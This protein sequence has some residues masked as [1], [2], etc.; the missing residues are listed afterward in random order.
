[1]TK[2]SG[3]VQVIVLKIADY[4]LSVEQISNLASEF[5]GEMLDTGNTDVNVEVG[6][7]GISAKSNSEQFKKYVDTAFIRKQ[8]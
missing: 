7:G 1:M 2:P 6:F 4:T 3:N 5:Y 8:S